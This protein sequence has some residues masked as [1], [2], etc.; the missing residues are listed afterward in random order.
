MHLVLALAALVDERELEQRAHIGALAG[1]GYEERDVGSAILA[2]LPV[3]VEVDR[4]VES[5]DVEGLG[6]DE[7]PHPD[8]LGEGVARDLE[9]VGA[10]HRLGDRRGRRLG[11]G[12]GREGGGGRGERRE[13]PPRGGAGGGVG[14]GGAAAADT[15][16]A[17]RGGTG[18]DRARVP[19]RAAAIRHGSDGSGRGAPDSDAGARGFEGPGEI[20]LGE[21][22]G[23][24]NGDSR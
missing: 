2:A 22:G 11:G 21:F 24:W 4:P 15:A 3:G 10:V 6:G 5:P 19:P 1:E 7:L 20:D 23:G 9:V 18:G 12:R 16:G 17:H 8:P 13:R 14:G